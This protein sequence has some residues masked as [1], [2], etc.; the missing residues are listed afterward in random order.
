MKLKSLLTVFALTSSL[1]LFG[2]KEGHDDHDHDHG[3]GHEH[4]HGEHGEK[5]EQKEGAEKATA[6]EGTNATASV[7]AN[8]KPYPLETCIVADSKLG[9]MGE[10]FVLVHEGQEVKFCC[11]SCKPK[12][13]A[14]PA[15]YLAK[16]TPDAK[17]EPVAN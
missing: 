15:K 12:F 7:T 17:P 1:S 11:E 5:G 4:E 6:V 13:D 8:A 2:C 3:P 14:D 16:L 10:P 9:S